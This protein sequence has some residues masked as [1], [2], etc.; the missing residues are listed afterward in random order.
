MRRLNT[1]AA[2]TLVVLSLPV[3][4]SAIGV[5]ERGTRGLIRMYSADTIG[6]GVLHFDLA[7]MYYTRT[8]SIYPPATPTSG[9]LLNPGDPATEANYHLFLS[10][11]GLTYGL[12]EYAE[13]GGSLMVR[14]WLLRPKD[15]NVLKDFDRGGLGDTDFSIKLRAPIPSEEFRLGV[16]GQATFPTGNEERGFTIGDTDYR[17][18]GL[19]TVNLSDLDTFV[20]I[21][22][23]ANGGY[24]FNR[25]E[26]EGYGIFNPSAPGLSGFWPPAY[27]GDSLASNLNGGAVPSDFNND[28]FT[29][30]GGIE[31]I[32]KF[33]LFG[34]IYY[35]K[36]LKAELPNPSDPTKNLK[37]NLT[38]VTLGFA[39]RDESGVS[40]K[41]AADIIPTSETDP[42]IY[43]QPDWALHV[44]LGFDI[45]VVPSDSDKDGIP[46]KEDA[47]PDE[48]EDVDGFMDSDG[49]P[50]P[51][52]DGDGLVD[53][54]DKCPD[55]S[56]DF[57]GNEDDDGC[58]DFDNDGDGI[59]DAEDDCPNQ[60]EDFDGDQDDDG[61][62]DLVKDTDEDGVPDD[63]DR[64]PLKPEDVDGFQDEDGCPDLDN[65][66]DGIPDEVDSC[67]NAPETFN[68]FEDEDGCPDERPIEQQFILRG[69]NFETGSAAITPDS[70]AI[71]DQV[72][73]TLVYYPEV[74]VEIRGYTDSVGS[75]E[76]NLRLSQRR[77]DSVRQ[78][79][80]NSGIEASRLT[81]RGLGEADPVASNA[82]PD[83]RSQNRRIEFH[84][85]N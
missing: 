36:L 38:V 58:P 75:E 76:S 13:L 32:G 49:C 15:T 22:I 71:L 12:S 55:L 63:A 40:L 10:R 34:E 51:D 1:L 8:D 3:A 66:L 37:S 64:C 72:V 46:D 18:L 7:S 9:W 70:Y 2:I 82:T 62:P 6:K 53:S 61:C 78:Y 67:P 17:V 45:E 77:A 85:L 5:A 4:A 68:G 59:A 23:H 30:S 74:R 47:C 24:Y 73:K 28:A 84:R 21:R 27:P 60:P 81:A 25:N 11:V 56:E 44:S 54:E 20:P 57:D 43:N 52:N 31:F 19:M 16:L 69:V 41:A 39:V 83:G 14:N 65:D 48:A 29:V 42:S 50:D 80:V 35:E 79:L 26:S 33:S